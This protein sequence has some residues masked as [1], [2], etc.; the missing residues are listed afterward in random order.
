MRSAFA[1]L[2]LFVVVIPG[3]AHHS[4]AEYDRSI[5]Q[6]LE[7]EVLRVMW[8][9]PHIRLTLR[10]ENEDGEGEIWDLAGMDLNNLDRR[11]VPP[12]LVKVGDVIRVSGNP[13]V[14]TERHMDVINLLTPDGT[15]IMISP[16]AEP[17]WSEIVVGLPGSAGRSLAAI[18]G[19]AIFRVWS[20]SAT[21]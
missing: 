10:R 13:S 14:R 15:E 5:R 4:R 19:P 12:D 20:R 16:I 9:N 3:W 7:G 8:R 6:E 1:T 21:T 18:D 11:D 17:L 2:A